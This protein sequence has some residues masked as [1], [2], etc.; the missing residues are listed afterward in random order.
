MMAV[1]FRK[2][3]LSLYRLLFRV[4]NAGRICK[5]NAQR[6]LKADVKKG[7]GFG[8]KS[9]GLGWVEQ[10]NKSEITL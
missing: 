7:Q 5:Y 4:M 10:C 9:L 1:D 6:A 3:V 8:S 2:L